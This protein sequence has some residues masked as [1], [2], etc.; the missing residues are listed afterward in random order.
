MTD[1]H[2]S[3]IAQKE[4]IMKIDINTV[5]YWNKIARYLVAKNK[6]DPLRAT[7]VY[8]ILSMGQIK[9][10]GEIKYKKMIEKIRK[11]K[12]EGKCIKNEQK[13][14]N[15]L[16]S[17]I[18]MRLYPKE[19]ELIEHIKDKYEEKYKLDGIEIDK[20]KIIKIVSE[21][22]SDERIEREKKIIKIPKGEEYWKKDDGE[23]LEPYWGELKP[24]MINKEKLTLNK[25]PKYG[26]DKFLKEVEIVRKISDKRSEDQLFIAK[27]WADGVGTS[28]PP[29]HWNRIA[30][31]LIIK[32]KLS[33]KESAS[34]L[35]LLNC[36]LMDAGIIC[37]KC[38]YL[39]WF[40]R[41]YQFDP[42]ITTPIGKPNHPSYVSGHSTFSATASHVLSWFFPC[43]YISL[44]EAADESSDSRIFGGIHYPSDCYD[45]LLLGEQVASQIASKLCIDFKPYF[46]YDKL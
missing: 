3:E 45:G 36:S 1:E 37:W 16:S 22:C 10:Y 7:I 14:M 23:P 25:P 27:K 26:S 21:I 19:N 18:L 20:N 42:C 17:E 2:F 15:Y 44:L 31:R 30:S 24:W 29:G 33:L 8:S 39:Y 12:E 41:P 4:E 43:W 34:V 13:V 32:F 5:V 6:E 38:K 35:S 9:I 11:E 46:S 40:I 28:T